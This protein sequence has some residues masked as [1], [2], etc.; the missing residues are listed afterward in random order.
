MKTGRP[1]NKPERAAKSMALRLLTGRLRSGHEVKRYLTN[2]GFSPAVCD[3]VLV[4]LEE[5]GY[6]NDKEFSRSWV[7]SKLPKRGFIRLRRDLW[8]K[9]ISRHL[10]NQVLDE[11]G[12]AEEYRAAVAFMEKERYRTTEGFDLQKI[13]VSL[14][15]RGYSHEVIHKIKG[16]AD[17]ANGLPVVGKSMGYE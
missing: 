10:V 14:N 12:F 8:S 5:Y 4:M 3:P 11:F 15:R 2:K 6:I 17:S 13:L 1:E 9:G 16:C 7:R